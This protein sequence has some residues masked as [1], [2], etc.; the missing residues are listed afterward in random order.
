MVFM[1]VNAMADGHP[2]R[3]LSEIDIKFLALYCDEDSCENTILILEGEYATNPPTYKLICPNCKKVFHSDA[4]P[5][6]VYTQR[7]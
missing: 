2:I 1:E 3:R 6:I 5:G 7:K 4:K